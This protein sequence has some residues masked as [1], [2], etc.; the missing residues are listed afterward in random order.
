MKEFWDGLGTALIIL[1]ICFG[2][3]QCTKMESEAIKMRN[4]NSDS[5]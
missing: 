5:K 4:C 1:A 2:I 3:G